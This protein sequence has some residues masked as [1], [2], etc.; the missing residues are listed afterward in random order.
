VS[1]ETLSAKDFFP[2]RAVLAGRRTNREKL[3]A[4]PSPV[5][6]IGGWRV[7]AALGGMLSPRQ[8]RE[9]VTTATTCLPATRESMTPSARIA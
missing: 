3:P 6:C 2:K 4:V 5:D 7:L 1:R 9:H 8:Q